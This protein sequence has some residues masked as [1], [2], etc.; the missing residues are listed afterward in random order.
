MRAGERC[1]GDHVLEHF[2]CVVLDQPQIGKRAFGDELEQAAN[3]RRMNLDAEVIVL[4]VRLRDLRGGFAHAETD[5][6]DR[7]R[8]PAEHLL[9][10]QNA[11]RVG[12]AVDGQQ[13]IDRAPLRV[14]YSAL[15]QHEAAY[16]RMGR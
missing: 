3:A 14:G 2:D 9:E 11:R 16:R 13:G 12:D 8:A 7:R 10:G 6:E 5:L 1:G 15:A 4:R